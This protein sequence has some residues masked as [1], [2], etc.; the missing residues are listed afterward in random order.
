MKPPHPAIRVLRWLLFVP[1]SALSLWA[2]LGPPTGETMV[3]T[4][5][6]LATTVGAFLSDQRPRRRG[7]TVGLALCCTALAFRLVTADRG[8]TVTNISRNADTASNPGTDTA[9]NTAT[10]RNT[11]SNTNPNPTTLAHAG[12]WLDRLVPERELAIGGSRLLLLLDRLPGDEPGLLQHLDDGYTRMRAAEGTVP[13]PVLGTFLL[14]QTPA[15]HGVLRVAP[16]PPSKPA[17]LVFLHGYI[18]STTL[19][20]WQVA[21]GARPLGVETV[22]PAMDWRA[23]WDSPAGRAIARR[24]I[25][26]LRASGVEHITLAGLSA[27]AIGASRIGDDLDIDALILISG[28][29]RRPTPASVPT[30]VLQGAQDPMTPA[31]LARAFA[32]RAPRARYVELPD[33]GH[34]MVLS[35]HRRVTSETTRFLRPLLP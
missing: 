26:D 29:S 5:G 28:A 35:Q 7:L 9:S 16:A 4:V 22:C 25:A 14:G 18:G 34:W 13:S 3:F 27:G 30:L 24:T 19:S 12:R 23:R 8:H 31:P 17:A 6:I 15:D 33:A 10:S 20:C 21:Q 2:L 11:A 1:L 32:R